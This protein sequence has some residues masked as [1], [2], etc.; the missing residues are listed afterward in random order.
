[1]SKIPR[2]LSDKDMLK[3]FHEEPTMEEMLLAMDAADDTLVS[4][5]SSGTLAPP[6]YRQRKVAKG[7][8]DPLAVYLSPAGVDTLVKALLD[9]KLAL[10]NEGIVNYRMEVKREGTVIT[11]TPVENQQKGR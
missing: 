5:R 8:D 6:S 4:C 10:Y 11:L 1:M 3:N 9:V 2:G 7:E